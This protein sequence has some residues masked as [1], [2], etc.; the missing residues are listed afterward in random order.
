M[1]DPII[2]SKNIKEEFISYILTTFSFA[3]IG[4]RKQFITELN[5][6]ISNGPWL[7]TND[8]FES[9]S[10]VNKLIDEGVLSKLYRD[11]EAKKPNGKLY[12]RCLPIDM[13]SLK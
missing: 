2:A 5:D 9:G 7:E 4:L 13:M 12:K 10:T 1:F 3:D 6:I 8:V 11:L